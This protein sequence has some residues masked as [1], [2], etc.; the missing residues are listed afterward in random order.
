M[1]KRRHDATT[2]SSPADKLLKAFERFLR[3]E[4]G[5]G[6]V[7]LLATAVALIW[8]NSPWHEY[9]ERIWDAR[10]SFG[11][12]GVDV[13]RSLHFSIN[14]GLMT[15][16]FLVVGLEIRLELRE[17]ALANRRVATLPLA[18]AV[19]GV[20]VPALI[21]LAFN[22][23]QPARAGWAIPMA[24]DIAFAVGILALLGRLVPASLRAFLLALAIVDDI[25]AVLV[26]TFFY[27]DGVSPFGLLLTIGGIGG[28]FLLQRLDVRT[29]LPY[30]LPGS[31]IWFGLL[32]AGI[33]PT[34]AGVILGLA[35]P[36]ATP[37][38]KERPLTNAR[39]ALNEL[40]ERIGSTRDSNKLMPPVRELKR[41]ERDLLA[42]A[43]RVQ[44]AL[45]PWVAYGVM[46]L[47]ALANAG[48]RVDG[49]SFEDPVSASI[50]GGI[51]AGLVIGKPLGIILATILA[52]KTGLCSLPASIGWRGV[53][54]TGC[55]GGI[56]FTMSLFIAALAFGDA[57]LLAPAKFAVLI[58][59]SLAMLAGLIVG[60]LAFRRR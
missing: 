55:L 10:L 30:L 24:T 8:A 17:G 27:S 52:V 46:P 23:E 5:S 37:F 59:S 11:I 12:G 49:L 29:V 39:D 9:Y 15:I 36:V 45:H 6:I 60:W 53:V 21:F 44:A 54:V 38:S 42:P 50:A 56:G 22:P 16:F 48:V 26:I 57:A 51:V 2:D 41:A 31:I 13:V 3:V 34:I 32:S 19:G 58:A 47:F 18:A 4:A 43:V 7:L 35:T 33:H 14:E 1:G 28:V 40:R 25:L 20:L